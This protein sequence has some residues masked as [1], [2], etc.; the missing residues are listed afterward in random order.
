MKGKAKKLQAKLKRTS[1]VPSDITGEHAAT[2]GTDV[3]VEQDAGP[4]VSAAPAAEVGVAGASGDAVAKLEASNAALAKDLQDQKEQYKK[5]RNKANDLQRKLKA[6]SGLLGAK[7][8]R[9]TSDGG[10][11]TWASTSKQTSHSS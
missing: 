11:C 8:K 4:L 9:V 6:K 1:S 2:A 3:P 10:E 5:M 7:A